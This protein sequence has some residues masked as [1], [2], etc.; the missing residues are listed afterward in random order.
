MQVFPRYRSPAFLKEHIFHTM[1]FYHPRCIDRRGGY[2]HFFLDDGTAYDTGHRHLVNSTRLIYNYAQ[3]H[4]HFRA[5]T[6]L[7]AVRH[8]LAFLRE[9]HLD[10]ATGRY[11][12]ML[13][14]EDRP[15]G[16]REHVVEDAAQYA[17]GLGFVM[18][19]YAHALKAGVAEAR[20]WLAEAWQTLNTLFWD[21]AQGL[22]ADELAE[23]G[24][25]SPYRGQNANMH[26]FEALLGAFEATGETTYLDRAEHIARR[27]TVDLADRT[28]GHIWEHFRA[29]WT[30]DWHFHRDQP[31]EIFRPWGYQFGHQ[32]EWAKLLL[33]LDRLRPAPWLLPRAQALFDFTVAHGWDEE[34]R[35]LFNRMAPDGSL[36][37]DRKA[38]WVQSETATAAALLGHRTGLETYW[39]WYDRLWSY[40]WDYFIDHEHGAWYHTLTRDNRRLGEEKTP[41]GRLDYHT[42]GNCYEMLRVVAP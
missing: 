21:E 4:L 37:D 28:D 16:T 36:C 30:P 12:W 5:P 7:D 1:A 20:D 23:D 26:V 10:A 25:W 33:I 22:Y 40:C 29:D 35:G 2:F 32:A 39:R 24:R 11:A 9:A 14:V 15:D 27:V 8:G 38:F 42:L 19:A 34:A 13:R 31:D 6:Y 18:L 41:V 3:A 17:Y